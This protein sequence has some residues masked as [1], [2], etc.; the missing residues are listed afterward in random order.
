M[1]VH[2]DIVNC[3]HIS[4]KISISQ[5]IFA[6]ANLHIFAGQAAEYLIVLYN[7]IPYLLTYVW[8]CIWRC[9]TWAGRR[10]TRLRWQKV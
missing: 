5:G 3:I 10:G 2:N 6:S 1:Y 8:H 4:P 7:I 9:Y